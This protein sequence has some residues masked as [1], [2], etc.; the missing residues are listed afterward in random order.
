[1]PSSSTAASNVPPKGWRPAVAFLTSALLCLVVGCGTDS[2]PPPPPVEVAELGIA[3]PGYVDPSDSDYWQSV[4][5]AAPQVRDVIVNP[6]SGPGEAESAPH[7]QLIRKLRDAGVRVLGYVSTGWGARDEAAVYSEIDRYR[8]W[9]G[10]NDIFLDEA[11]AVPEEVDTYAEYSARVHEAGG[12]V[13]LNPGLLPDRGYFEYADAI[14][15]FEDSADQ[16]FKAG[17][18]PTWLTETSA[19]VWHIVIGSPQDRLSGVVDRAREHGADKVYVT[20][21]VKPNPYDRLPRYWQGKL[22]AAAI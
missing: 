21:D 16:Y 4:I 8:E 13:V 18:P 1:M 9:Y 15:T 17:T 10:V 7:V 5:E 20:D 12:I 6:N 22:E 19:E 3:V 11:A 2:P 14:V